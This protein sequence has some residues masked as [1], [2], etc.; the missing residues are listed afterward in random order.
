[1]ILKPFEAQISRLY[2]GPSVF[3][4]KQHEEWKRN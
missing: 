1:M 2:I 3:T 4:E